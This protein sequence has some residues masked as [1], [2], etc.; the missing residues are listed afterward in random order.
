MKKKES[1]T[2]QD[3]MVLKKKEKKSFDNVFAYEDNN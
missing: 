3:F 2:Y 1:N